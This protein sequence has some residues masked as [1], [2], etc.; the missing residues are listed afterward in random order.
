MHIF[1]D[2]ICKMFSVKSQV[3][4]LSSVVAAAEGGNSCR[5]TRGGSQQHAGNQWQ[6][7]NLCKSDLLTSD[8]LEGPFRDNHYNRAGA[9]ELARGGRGATAVR[10]PVSL[11]ACSLRF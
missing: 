6:P 8:W 1:T 3:V 9:K 5:G 10:V 7:V 4:N 11:R 2:K